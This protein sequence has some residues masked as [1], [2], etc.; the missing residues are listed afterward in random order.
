VINQAFKR[1]LELPQ[2]DRQI[3]TFFIPIPAECYRH[4]KPDRDS[5][6]PEHD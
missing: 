3:A 5:S 2:Q 1:F 6:K 4:Q